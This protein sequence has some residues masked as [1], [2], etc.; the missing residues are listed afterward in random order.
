MDVVKGGLAGPDRQLLLS[1]RERLARNTSVKALSLP[2]TIG[3]NCEHQLAIA[4]HAMQFLLHISSCIF[5]PP[6]QRLR[7]LTLA[8]SVPTISLSPRRPHHDIFSSIL[9]VKYNCRVCEL[10]IYIF[11]ISSVDDSAE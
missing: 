8:F 6:L 10:D 5:P 4:I 1:M 2:F 7:R 3:K 9:F 11:T